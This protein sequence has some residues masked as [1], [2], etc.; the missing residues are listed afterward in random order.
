MTHEI[1]SISSLLDY[2]TIFLVALDLYQQL[3]RRMDFRVQSWRLSM[4]IYQREPPLDVIGVRD[5]TVVRLCSLP[6]RF[7][8]SS[9]GWQPTGFFM[10][11]SN[12]QQEQKNWHV[13]H[14]HS[15]GPPQICS[16]RSV[17][18]DVFCVFHRIDSVV[19]VH[20]FGGT[21]PFGGHGTIRRVSRGHVNTRACFCLFCISFLLHLPPAVLTFV[22]IARSSRPVP[23]LAMESMCVFKCS[24]TVYSHACR[25]QL[26]SVCL[27][28]LRVK[29]TT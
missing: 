19:C 9:R 5:F 18:S 14:Q 28:L 26:L 11:A 12:L 23:S 21:T 25:F 17:W 13:Y 16:S 29:L 22:I 20:L 4:S 24:L 15:P 6:R 8:S 3:D 7:R 27:P 2:T 1:E 10:T